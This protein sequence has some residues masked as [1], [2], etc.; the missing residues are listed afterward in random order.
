MAAGANTGNDTWNGVVGM[1]QRKVITVTIQCFIPYVYWAV[2][3]NSTHDYVC[4]TIYLILFAQPISDTKVMCAYYI[5][6][7]E[8]TLSAVEMLNRYANGMCYFVLTLM[9]TPRQINR[10]TINRKYT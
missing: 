8:E 6:A 4:F 2:L 5:H 10:R 9:Q 3:T 1:L 7:C